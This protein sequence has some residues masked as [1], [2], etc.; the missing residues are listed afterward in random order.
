GL[1]GSFA[2]LEL[3][4]AGMS[5]LFVEQAAAPRNG[6]NPQITELHVELALGS[7]PFVSMPAG[8]AAVGGTSVIY[9]AALERPERHDIEDMPGL[10]HPTGSWPVGFDALNPILAE[11]E[12][13]LGV[14][15]EPDP[16]GT[17]NYA[18]LKP[19]P[20]MSP[21]DAAIDL[22]LRE[23]GLHPY[24]THVGIGYDAACLECIGR[25]CPRKCKGEARTAALMPALATGRAALLD[26]A[27]ALRLETEGDRVTGLV[28]EREGVLLTLRGKRFLLGAGALASAQLLLASQSAAWPDGLA[29]RSGLVGRNL[30]FH[31]SERF[32]IWPP[33]RAPF[34]MPAKTLALRDMY[35]V[36]TDRFGVVQSMGLSA[37]YGNVL[38]YLYE[39]FDR[40]PLRRVTPLRHLLRIPARLAAL[41]LGH[42]RIFVGILEDPPDAANRVLPGSEP[43]KPPRLLYRLSD[44]FE[45]RRHRYR[46]AI[47]QALKGQHWFFLNYQPEL[48]LPH[49]CG[50]ARFG[51]DSRHSV[52]DAQCRAHDLRNLWVVDAS[53]M[54]TATGVNPGLLIAAN[55]MR[56]GRA[57]VN[58]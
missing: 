24:R 16:L 2:G 34:A 40:G 38:M 15:G 28:V 39:R 47:R 44:D 19:P 31:L 21:G 25:P 41:A 14:C 50:T 32:A 49:A 11:A 17:G 12:G 48:N 4:R 30:M 46:L 7:G 18:H 53:F 35:R 5:V 6:E 51:H 52:L 56:V 36:G 8:V 27:R 37:D 9:A 1:A 33:S 42:A 29:N 23:Q 57:I 26:R 13:M 3:A 10:P 45:H 54:P 20:P 55:S 43:G 58:E 22:A